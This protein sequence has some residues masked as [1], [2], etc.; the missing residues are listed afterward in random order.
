MSSCSLPITIRRFTTAD[1]DRLVEI[2]NASFEVDALPKRELLRLRRRCFSWAIAAELAGEIVAYMVT[3][4]EPHKQHTVAH[5]MILAVDPAYRR[6]GVGTALVN[7]SFEYVN[8]PVALVWELEVRPSNHAGMSFWQSF[9]FVPIG[10]KARL[11][12]D[13]A[14]AIHMQRQ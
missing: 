6:Q 13:K 2:G 11:Y 4:I 7:W 9:G 12:R 8:G 1:V 14:D 10:I 3:C 5:I